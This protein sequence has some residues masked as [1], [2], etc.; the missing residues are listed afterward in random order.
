METLTSAVQ[1]QSLNF[2]KHLATGQ[3][4]KKGLIGFSHSW[5]S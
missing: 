3:F 2:V 5:A 4:E 1:S